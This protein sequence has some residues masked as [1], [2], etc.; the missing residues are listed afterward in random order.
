VQ[1]AFIE[2]NLK[3]T[4]V[5]ES[6]IR[7]SLSEHRKYAETG[8]DG[9]G[10]RMFKSVEDY[11][12]R[13]G[14]PDEASFIR[15][16]VVPGLRY[17]LYFEYQVKDEKLKEFFQRYSSAM[18]LTQQVRASH[19]LFKTGTDPVKNDEIREKAEKVL[20][21]LHNGAQF[22]VLARKYSDCPSKEKGGDLGYFGPGRMVRPF[23]ETAFSL[24]KGDISSLVKTRFGWHIILVT[25][26]RKAKTFEQ[27]REQ[28]MSGYIQQLKNRH[29]DE[30]I[31]KAEITIHHDLYSDILRN[32]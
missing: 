17:H 14:C 3:N 31:E 21:E 4:P 13:F 2:K 12:S 1:T 11:F 18:G 7:K 10:N 25:D 19:I 32:R 5:P 30:L 27:A 26:T 9:Q 28:V 23:E 8:K 22:S 6:K 15:E 29:M 16:V 20:R 24:K